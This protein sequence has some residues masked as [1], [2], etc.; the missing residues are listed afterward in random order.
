MITTMSEKPNKPQKKAPQRPNMRSWE[1]DDDVAA[2]LDDAEKLGAIKKEIIN[3]AL[4]KY[5]PAALREELKRLRHEIDEIERRN[6]DA[7][8]N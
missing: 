7:G 6:T 2:L 5:G 3:K 8:K 4:R 1:A